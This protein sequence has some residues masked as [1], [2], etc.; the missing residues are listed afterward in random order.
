MARQYRLLASSP[1]ALQLPFEA[2]QGDFN[3]SVSAIAAAFY[4][5]HAPRL[6]E[7]A[8]QCN[9]ATWSAAQVQGS[10]H[11]T[12]GKHSPEDKRRL[13]AVL[14]GDAE[15]RAHL[16]A[17]A[18]AVGYADDPRCRGDGDAGGQGQ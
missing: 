17:V 5:A 7:V 16:C 3:G 13:L 8:Q 1:G 15:V 2:M 12:A 10:N 18:A 9:P 11:V 14:A 4:P 6:M